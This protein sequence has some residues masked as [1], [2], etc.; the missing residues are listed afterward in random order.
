M[1]G[2]LSQALQFSGT[3]TVTRMLNL[4]VLLS[5]T[6]YCCVCKQQSAKDLSRLTYMS[7][8]K[9]VCV[10]CWSAFL[11]EL[12][13]ALDCGCERALSLLPLIGLCFATMYSC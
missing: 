5:R 8:C 10:S 9:C 1:L 7:Q 12:K 6:C 2:R 13:V 11:C 4:T 3:M